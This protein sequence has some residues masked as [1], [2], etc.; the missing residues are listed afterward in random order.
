MNLILHQMSN[1]LLHE[2]MHPL[3]DMVAPQNCKVV[4]SIFS[5]PISLLLCRNEQHM[6]GN[7]E[8]GGR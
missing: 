3:G 8:R 4:I 1:G 6:V 2:I 5:A 7:G